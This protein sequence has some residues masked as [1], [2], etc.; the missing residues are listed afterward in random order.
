VQAKTAA[1]DNNPSLAARLLR[2][3]KSAAGGL[4]ALAGS[5]V[6]RR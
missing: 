5:V 2:K 1:P 4:A 3:V 6:G